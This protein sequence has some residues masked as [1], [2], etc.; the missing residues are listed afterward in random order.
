MAD[1]LCNRLWACRNH[2][3]GEHCELS[4]LAREVDA[5]PPKDFLSEWDEFYEACR[6][7]KRGNRVFPSQQ[8]TVDFFNNVV[9]VFDPIAKKLCGVGLSYQK[10]SSTVVFVVNSRSEAEHVYSDAVDLGWK[11]DAVV[12]TVYEGYDRAREMYFSR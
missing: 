10:K 3:N 7:V 12:V 8:N 6:V 5:S 2:Y 11:L 4:K 1:T 9:D